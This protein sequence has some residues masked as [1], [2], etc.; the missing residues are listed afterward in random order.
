MITDIDTAGLS[1]AEVTA[2]LVKGIYA[3]CRACPGGVTT[4]W[5]EPGGTYVPVHGRCVERMLTEIAERTAG[6]VP[7]A[8]RPTGR[9]TGAY[10]RRAAAAATG[11]ARPVEKGRVSRD[12]GSPFFRPGMAEGE[13]WVIVA[14]TNL[15]QWCRLDK[16]EE[17]ARATSRRW[18]LLTEAGRSVDSAGTAMLGAVL[19]TATGELSEPWGDAVTIGSPRW[20]GLS[21]LSD[22]TWCSSCRNPLWPLRMVTADGRCSVCARADEESDPRP[23]WPSEP[24]DPGVAHYPVWLGGPRKSS[25]ARAKEVS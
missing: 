13:P 17:H 14:D 4:Y 1:V 9:L 25:R 21:R 2:S 19:V 10:A 12:L 7:Q 23:C 24:S 3:T 16:Q 5:R 20:M 8:A 11:S 22:W 6:G 15:G 18:R